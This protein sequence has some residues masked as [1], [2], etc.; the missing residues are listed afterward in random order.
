MYNKLKLKL[1]I[2]LSRCGRNFTPSLCRKP[3]LWS[4]GGRSVI[5]GIFTI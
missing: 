5:F 3:F 4:N 2:F 1:C